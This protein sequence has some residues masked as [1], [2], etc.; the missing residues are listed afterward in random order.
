MWAQSLSRGQRATRV[1]GIA[2]GEPPGDRRTS[3]GIQNPAVDA[4]IEQVIFAKD[5][6]TQIAAT[7]RSIACCCGI[8]TFG[9]ALTSPARLRYARLGPF[10]SRRTAAEIRDSG[11]PTQWWYDADKAARIGKRS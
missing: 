7:R 3:A 6:A 10:Q 8:S 2:G 9:A 5:R 1:L 11:F 4:M